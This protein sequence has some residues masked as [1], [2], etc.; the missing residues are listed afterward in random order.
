MAGL[1]FRPAQRLRLPKEFQRA[2]REGRRFQN[3]W[4]SANVAPNALGMPR[5]GLAIAARVV[6]NAVHRN[7]LRRRI[8]ESFRLRQREMPAVDIVIGARAA[9]RD[10]APEAINAALAR[11]WE[12]V[13]ALC[14][15]SSKA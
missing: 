3:A 9:A 13:I 8:R 6:G 7:R 5:L 14:V 12:Q 1:R 10:A 15:P 2:Y 11:L 4:L